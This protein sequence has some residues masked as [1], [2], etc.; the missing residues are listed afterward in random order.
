M[1]GEAN[2]IGGTPL[3]PA[4]VASMGRDYAHEMCFGDHYMVPMSG[5]Y[6]ALRGRVNG[7]G[8]SPDE[9]LMPCLELAGFGSTTLIRM[10]DLW[11][12]LISALVERWRPD[13]HT[14]H[15]PCGECNVTLED[16]AL[17]LGLPIDESAVTGIV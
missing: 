3:I 11:Y 16:V 14:F 8:Y 10:F 7:L 12:D 5:P 15:L 17:Q 4:T 9:R 13:T 2:L 6:C 1:G